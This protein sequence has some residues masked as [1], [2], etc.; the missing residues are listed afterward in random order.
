MTLDQETVLNLKDE[1]AYAIDQQQLAEKKLERA[2]DAYRD[3]ADTVGHWGDRVDALNL[4]V[5][6]DDAAPVDNDKFKTFGEA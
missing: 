6:Q 4:L 2:L 1:L 5:A 3:A